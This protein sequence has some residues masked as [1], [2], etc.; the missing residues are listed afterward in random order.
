MVT[1]CY[2]PYMPYKNILHKKKKKKKFYGWK[3]LKWTENE[4][5]T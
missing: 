2:W 4:D 3:V 5:C 1:Q